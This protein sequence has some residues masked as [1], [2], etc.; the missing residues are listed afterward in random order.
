MICNSCG[1]QNEDIAVFCKNCGTKLHQ[2]QATMT[3]GDPPGISV[4]KTASGSGAVL[5]AAIA[6]SVKVGFTLLGILAVMLFGTVFSQLIS[7]FAY[8]SVDEFYID[9]GYSVEQFTAEP[10]VST[11]IL[12]VILLP[13]IALSIIELVGIWKIYAASK[14][15]LGMNTSGFS[16]MKAAAIIRLATQALLLFFALIVGYFAKDAPNPSLNSP[17]LDISYVIA[18]TIIVIAAMIMVLNIIFNAKIVRDMNAFRDAVKYGELPKKPSIFVIAIL[19]ILGGIGGVNIAATLPATV[20]HF[21]LAIALIICRSQIS[22]LDYDS[23]G[24]YVPPRGA[25]PAGS[26]QSEAYANSKN[27]TTSHSGEQYDSTQ[28]EMH[29]CP[30]CGLVCGGTVCPRCGFHMK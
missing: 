19:F 8:E 4:I 15:P 18:I 6:Q 21:A 25:A 17:M 16:W 2:E 13:T 20:Y 30:G 5:T 24:G 23:R 1:T 22:K 10:I 29:T 7:D 11:V 27:N 26:S 12:A 9:P 28:S 3:Q 14:K